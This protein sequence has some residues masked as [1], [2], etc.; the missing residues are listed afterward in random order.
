MDEKGNFP[1]PCTERNLKTELSSNLE[2]DARPQTN[3]TVYQS[4]TALCNAT[5]VA[6]SQ[7]GLPYCPHATPRPLSAVVSVFIQQI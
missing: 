6:T 1:T 7:D 2:L 4:C 3:S 5:K